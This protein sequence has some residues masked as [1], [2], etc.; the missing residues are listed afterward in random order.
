[1]ANHGGF[2]DNGLGNRLHGHVSDDRSRLIEPHLRKVLD[3]QTHPFHRVG[4]GV[5]HTVDVLPGPLDTRSGHG[6]AG[7]KD[8]P[9]VFDPCQGRFRCRIAN[10]NACNDFHC[11]T[12]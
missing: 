1:M 5:E 4:Q 11:G 9:A 2:G 8:C 12:S 3:L 7:K 6:A 10:V